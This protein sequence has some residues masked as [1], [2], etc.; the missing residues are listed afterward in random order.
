[1]VG[2]LNKINNLTNQLY[3]KYIIKYNLPKCT[4]QLFFFPEKCSLC[5]TSIKRDIYG[6]G[7]VNINI[8]E[9][10]NVTEQNSM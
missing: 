5:K 7:N 8:V 9:P 2:S 6:K 1:M 3:L 4:K 10:R